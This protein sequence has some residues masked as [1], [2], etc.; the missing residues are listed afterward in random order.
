[1]SLDAYTW[2]DLKNY[3]DGDRVALIRTT[4]IPNGYCIEALYR[5]AYILN[6]IWMCYTCRVNIANALKAVGVYF[7][8][9]KQDEKGEAVSPINTCGH[10]QKKLLKKV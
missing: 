8:I 9:D 5:R 2:Y 10:C 3:Q 7:D 6:G 1:V 4:N